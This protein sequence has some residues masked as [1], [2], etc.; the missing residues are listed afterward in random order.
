MEAVRTFLGLSIA[1]AAER[2]GI[3]E[4]ALV[5]YEN[6]EGEPDVETIQKF[7]DLFGM[8]IE[9]LFYVELEEGTTVGAF[10]RGV[11]DLEL[12]ISNVQMDQEVSKENNTRGLIA[13]LKAKKRCKHIELMD[14]IRQIEGVRY[15]EEL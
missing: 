7:C 1:A 10:I 6:Q 2:S 5:S 11:R 13:T 9:D 15:L 14:Q 8:A 4:S 3:P 12:E